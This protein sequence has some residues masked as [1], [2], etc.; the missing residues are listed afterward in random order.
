MSYFRAFGA[1][2]HTPKSASV[3]GIKE[4]SRVG[5]VQA[6]WNY[7]KLHSLQD[8]A[9]RRVIKADEKLLPVSHPFHV[10]L[11]LQCLL[12]ADFRRRERVLPEFAR[13]R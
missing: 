12:V 8:K 9:D 5:V 1:S 13:N 4:E 3:L 2:D 11:V 10:W 7:I 6:L